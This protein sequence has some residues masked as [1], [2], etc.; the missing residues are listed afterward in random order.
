MTNLTLGNIMQ[1]GMDIY[2]IAF[3]DS[4]SDYRQAGNLMIHYKMAPVGKEPNINY[5]YLVS[6][7]KIGFISEEEVIS[8]GKNYHEIARDRYNINELMY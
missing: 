6:V 4:V 8:S 5:K 1:R 2:E 3:R 7:D